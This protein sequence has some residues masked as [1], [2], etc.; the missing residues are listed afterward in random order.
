MLQQVKTGKKWQ[1]GLKQKN[2]QTTSVGRGKDATLTT[3][4]ADLVNISRKKNKK[5][6]PSIRKEMRMATEETHLSKLVRMNQQDECIKWEELM[7]SKV[8]WASN[9]PS[10]Q[11][12][13]ETKKITQSVTCAKDYKP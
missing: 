4:Q 9:F 6:Q 3:E 8:T 11:C 7:Q 2:K 5:Q 10:S 12:I 13:N 1:V